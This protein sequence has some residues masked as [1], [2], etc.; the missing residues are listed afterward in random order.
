MKTRKRFLILLGVAVFG[1]AIAAFLLIPPI[2]KDYETR[3]AAKALVELSEICLEKFPATTASEKFRNLR[4]CIYINSIFSADKVNNKIWKNVHKMAGM[5]LDYA[6]KDTNVPPP[7][8]CSNR[9]GLLVAMLKALG[10]NARDIVTA[11]DEDDFNDHVVMSV[12]NPETKRWEVHDPSYDVEFLS[13]KDRKPLGI[14][15]M[16]MFGTDKFEPCNFEG[17]CGWDQKNSEGFDLKF[18]KGYWN[19]AWIKAEKVMYVSEHFDVN[20]KRPV[21]GENL[22]YCDWRAKWCNNLVHLDMNTPLNYP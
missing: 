12:F 20:K 17:K 4:H 16:L 3:E 15:R 9:S 6:Q 19:V 10:Y 22:S 1:L 8:E 11:R 5:T 13:L 18:N 14:K 21:Y 2:K 7:M